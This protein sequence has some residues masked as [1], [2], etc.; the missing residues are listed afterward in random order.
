MR[1]N[2][3]CA[4][5]AGPFYFTGRRGGAH[6]GRS[7]PF[8][9]TRATARLEI[10]KAHSIGFNNPFKAL[11]E[12]LEALGTNPS[13][14]I[15]RT[16]SFAKMIPCLRKFSPAK[17]AMIMIPRIRRLLICFENKPSPLEII[18]LPLQTPVIH[19]NQGLGSVRPSG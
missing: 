15:F 17:I 19:K 13:S 2:V 10:S 7:G 16:I 3:S 6:G 18:F 11:F 1:H 14:F 12:V 9:P 8:R 5:K 4:G